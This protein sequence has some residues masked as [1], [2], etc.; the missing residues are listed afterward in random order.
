[1]KRITILGS[2]GSVGTQTLDVVRSQEDI[3]VIGLSAGSNIELLYRQILEFS[4]KYCCVRNREDALL[5]EE[6]PGVRPC[7]IW[8]GKEGLCRLAAEGDSKMVVTALVGMM[9]IEPTL[10]A[11]E[12][13]KD[14]ALANKETLVCAGHLI[15]P[16]ARERGVR[17]FPV[18]SEHSAVFQC[19]AGNEKNRIRRLF[20]TASGGPFRGYT[21][22]ALSRVTKEEALR[23]PNWS[24]GRKI[25]VDSSTMVNKGLEVLEAGWLFDVAPSQIEV[26]IQPTSL[27]HSMV[28]FEDGAILAQLGTPD[29]RLPIQYA[30]NY[31]KRLPALG[32][33]LDFTKISSLALEKPDLSVFEG[34]ALAYRVMEE[35]DSYPAVYNIAN[36][37]AVDAFLKDRIAY[38][39]ISRYIQFAVGCHHRVSSP[40]VEEILSLKEEIY[41]QL[42]QFEK[43]IIA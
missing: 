17:I 36:E 16:L 20:L 43:G 21:K 30:L 34:L 18:D 29:M 3:E 6:R 22:E 24:M 4:P 42:N 38:R 14:I 12:A 9:G 8:H 26:L 13:G 27:I 35:G 28:E 25:S 32:E 37:Y 19:L 15:M 31:P 5:L 2:T 7:Q 40:N 23:H 10:A 39:D 33:K 11:I 41:L 1:M